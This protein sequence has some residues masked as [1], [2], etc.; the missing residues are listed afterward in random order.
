MGSGKTSLGKQIA[1]A[2][3]FTF[4][5]MD[6]H[7]EE[8]QLMSVSQ[9]FTEKGEVEFRKLEK[10]CLHEVS[11]WRNVVIATGGGT[12]CFFDNMD[13]MNA[14]GLTVYLK[15]SVDELTSRLGASKKNKRPLIESLSG[16]KLRFFIQ[17]GLNKREPY[18]QQAKLIVHGTDEE[19]I[20]TI[21]QN[22]TLL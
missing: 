4:V 13:Y 18:Y 16:E 9:L 8:Q 21:V 19:I 17:E 10:A 2:L 7:I 11:E 5:D 22:N 3:N 14:H 1:K 6:H 12:A 20:A 15:L